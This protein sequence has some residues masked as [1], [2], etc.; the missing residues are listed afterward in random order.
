MLRREVDD[1]ASHAETTSSTPVDCKRPVNELRTA[2]VWKDVNAD[3]CAIRPRCWQRRAE[4]CHRSR[5]IVAV[6]DSG[7]MFGR[8]SINHDYIRETTCRED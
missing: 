3:D 4:V 5:R 8:L 7:R 2:L 1:L 6:G